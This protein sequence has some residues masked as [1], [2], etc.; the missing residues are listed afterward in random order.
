LHN[1]FV[2]QRVGAGTAELNKAACAALGF[3]FLFLFYQVGPVHYDR[4]GDFIFG[5]E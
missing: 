3:F 4:F 2:E 5:L 1:S